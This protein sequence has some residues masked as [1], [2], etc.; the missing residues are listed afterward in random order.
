MEKKRIV[1][2]MNGGIINRML[3]NFDDVEIEVLTVDQDVDG[4]CNEDVSVFCG[5]D[6]YMREELVECAPDF[7]NETYEFR[8]AFLNKEPS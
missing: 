6:V 4:L 8:E 3:S 1:I 7:V 2:Q 5:E